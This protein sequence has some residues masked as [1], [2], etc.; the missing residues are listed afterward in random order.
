MSESSIE[1]QV[2]TFPSVGDG[3]E[4]HAVVWDDASNAQVRGVIQFVHG[5]SEYI[6]RY[7]HLARFFVKQGFVVC[8]EDHIGHGQSVS[9]SDEWGVMPVKTGK[10]ILV[11][12]VHA[13]RLLIEE[14]YGKQTPYFIYGHSMGSFIARLYLAKHGADLA[15]CILSGTGSQ[16]AVVA[17]AGR[18]LARRSAASKGETYKSK[19]INGMADGA[20]GKAIKNARTSFDWLSTD[21]AVV[22]AY[23]ADPACGFM[24]SVGGY[25]VL[26]D[27][28]VEL[29]GAKHLAAL[30]KNVPV[31]FVAGADDPVG[32]RGRG[33]LKVFGDYRQ[34]GFADVKVRLFPGMR[35]EIHNEVERDMVY[36]ELLAWLEGHLS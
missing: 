16:P 7:D 26:M 8:G 20:Y 4:M 15:G 9:S 18:T 17:L 33:V 28:L 14:R 21:P 29:A 27:M 10:N 24:F 23:I 2:V 13:L 3:K 36:G 5:M 31:Y 25:A 32:D 30:P 1:M 35:H 11:E 34:A 22:D 12:N 19:T 6:E